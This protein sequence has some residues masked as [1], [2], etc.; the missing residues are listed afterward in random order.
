MNYKNSTTED[1]K[2]KLIEFENEYVI[3]KAN[4]IKFIDR[5]DYLEKENKKLLEELKNRKK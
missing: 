2:L 1:L 5:M 3:V 4:L